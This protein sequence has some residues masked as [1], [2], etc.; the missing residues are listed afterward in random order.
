MLPYNPIL[1]L[2]ILKSTAIIGR[3]L[4]SPDKSVLMK[5]IGLYNWL[6]PNITNLQV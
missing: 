3:I 5:G 1:R 6:S 4:I 2:A